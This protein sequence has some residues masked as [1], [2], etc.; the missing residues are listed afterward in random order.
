[1]DNS[2][3]D[4]LASLASEASKEERKKLNVEVPS[5]LKRK[6]KSRAALQGK[7][8]RTVVIEALQSHLEKG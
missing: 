1:M 4:N 3:N 2:Y 8:L 7:D 5:S 6:Y